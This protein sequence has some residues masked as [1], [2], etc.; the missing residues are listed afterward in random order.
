MLIDVYKASS[1]LYASQIECN[2]L[3]ELVMWARTQGYDLLLSTSAE[4]T[5]S[6]T[7]VDDY[8]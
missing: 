1:S 2:T 6:I 8:I 5:F 3:D 4:E 7:I